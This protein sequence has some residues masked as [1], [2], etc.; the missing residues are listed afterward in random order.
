[1][2]FIKIIVN[3]TSE[4]LDLII[5]ELDSVSFDFA[6]KIYDTQKHVEF[7]LEDGRGVMYAEMEEQQVKDWLAMYV[8]YG[9]NFSYEDITRSVLFR[10]IPPVN[11]EKREQLEA[12]IELFIE[13]NLDSDT[14][15]DKISEVGYDKL[16]EQ[17]FKILQTV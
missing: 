7:D 15:L 17:D 5:S 4:E 2:K 1:M 14:V 6:M 3:N 9:V 16:T 11:E 10:E 12:M 13:D 8:K